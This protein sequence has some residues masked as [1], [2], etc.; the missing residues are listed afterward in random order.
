MKITIK[1]PLNVN[2]LDR[3]LSMKIKSKRKNTNFVKKTLRFKI[4]TQ[5]TQRHTQFSMPT[6]PK[7]HNRGLILS[8]KAKS[9]KNKAKICNKGTI[10]RKRFCITTKSILMRVLSSARIP[11][12]NQLWNRTN[13][14]RGINNQDLKFK[15]AWCKFR[16]EIDRAIQTRAYIK[17]LMIN[18]QTKGLINLMIQGTTTKRTVNCCLRIASDH[19]NK[20]SW[21]VLKKT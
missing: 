17:K 18:R 14:I 3:L 7:Q 20:L 2:S 6:Y 21:S 5:F 8:S 13:F 11:F 9:L 19:I 1:G 15:T 16:R 4:K 12:Q 10:Y